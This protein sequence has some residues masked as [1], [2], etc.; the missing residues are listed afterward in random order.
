MFTH[1]WKGQF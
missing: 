1:L